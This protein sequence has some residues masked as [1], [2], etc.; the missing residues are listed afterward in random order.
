MFAAFF[1]YSMSLTRPA[2]FMLAIVIALSLVSANT[3][4]AGASLTC[5]GVTPIAEINRVLCILS[6]AN[7][8]DGRR[9]KLF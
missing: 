8:F 6:P 4:R 1:S 7:L 3:Q 5:R 2:L 9:K